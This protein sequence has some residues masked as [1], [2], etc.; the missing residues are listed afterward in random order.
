MRIFIAGC[1]RSGTTAFRAQFRGMA[2]AT[3]VPREASFSRFGEFDGEAAHVVLKRHA[4]DRFVLHEL[5]EDI[6]LF[7]CV[8][9]P[10]DVMTSSHAGTAHLR[11]YHV[12]PERWREE[13]EALERLED[14][15]PG[16][17]IFFVRYEDFVTDPARLQARIEGWL[18]LAFAEPFGSRRK[19]RTDSLLKWRRDPDR[20]N[21]LRA[22]PAR[23]EPHLAR[24]AARFAYSLD[25]SPV[26]A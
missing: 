17:D 26:A 11:P 23:L 19:L 2:D 1:A 22:L 12:E 18:G 13:F 8:R 24:F 14:R 10:Y 21:Y 5:P 16:R 20:I 9:H 7:Y 15:Q 3:V 6:R 4:R 25:L